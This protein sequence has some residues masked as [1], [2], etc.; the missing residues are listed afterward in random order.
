[1]TDL[2]LVHPPV[3]PPPMPPVLPLP[4]R[5]AVVRRAEVNAIALPGGRVY[6]FEGLIDKAETPD[7]LGGVIAHEM[8]HV[9][10]RDGVR[11]V[12]QAA[13]LSFL[14]GIL[15]GDFSGGGAAVIAMRT[16]LQSSYSRET[17]AAADVFG[18]E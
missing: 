4:V 1:M 2:A 11:A 14:F 8:C 12:M 6:V 5:A 7:G 3:A 9:A 18:A 13:G 16:V 17:E 15:I 10:H